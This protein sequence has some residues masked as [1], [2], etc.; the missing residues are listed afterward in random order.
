MGP[1]PGQARRCRTKPKGFRKESPE[2]LKGELFHLSE[3][4]PCKRRFY[5][6]SLGFL[7]RNQLL[8]LPCDLLFVRRL[9]LLLLSYRLRGLSLVGLLVLCYLC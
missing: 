6:R 5:N 9:V 4:V 8:S 3:D 2:I 1:P 7:S